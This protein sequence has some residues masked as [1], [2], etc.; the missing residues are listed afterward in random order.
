VSGNILQK[1]FAPHF[2]LTRSHLMKYL[3]SMVG[4]IVVT[5]VHLHAFC[6]ASN[7]KN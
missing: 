7:K 6:T 3:S 5:A 2:S 1:Y 4:P